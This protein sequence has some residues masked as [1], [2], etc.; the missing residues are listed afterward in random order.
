MNYLV[1]DI[2]CTCDEGDLLP[3]EE[4]ETIEIG[5]VLLNSELKPINEFSKFVRPVVHTQLREFCKTLTTITQEDVDAADTLDVV[6]DELKSF[7]EKEGDYTF[8]SWGGFD[9]RQLKRECERKEI[10]FELTTDTINYKKTFSKKRN[11]KAGSITKALK[12]LGGTFTGTH[13]RGIDDAK[14]IVQII[15]IIGM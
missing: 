15:D 3:R 13:H 12:G 7:C 5:A 2:E 11:H 6:I 8:V 10:P 9:Y 1:I 4:M 14:N